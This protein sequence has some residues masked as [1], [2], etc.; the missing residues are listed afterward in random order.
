M[1]TEADIYVTS[2]CRTQLMEENSNFLDSLFHM[3]IFIDNFQI[4]QKT[5][6]TADDNNVTE[7]LGFD[8]RTRGV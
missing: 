5:M 3:F 7:S 4:V 1:I 6:K 2:S 8:C